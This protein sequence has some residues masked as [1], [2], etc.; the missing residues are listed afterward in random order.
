M[1]E[2]EA[3]AGASLVAAVLEAA[4]GSSGRLEKEGLGGRISRLSDRV[5]EL[6]D[7]VCNMINQRYVEFLPSMQNAQDLE[8]EA[9]ELSSS[10]EQLKS[11]IET[12]VQQDLDVAIAEFT[13]LRQQ[14]ERDS[15]VLS[16][17]KQLQEID[18]ALKQFSA[19]LPE[20]KY[21]S[22]A[23][24]L[25]KA[26]RH[27]KMMES[28][29]GFELKILKALHIELVAQTQNI[30]GVLGEEWKQLAVWKLPQS[31]ETG[32]LESALQTEL[33]L[34]KTVPG[35]DSGVGSSAT[36]VLQGLAILGELNYRFKIFGQLL[37]NYVLKPLISHPSLQSLLEEQSDA[38]VLRLESVGT[39]LGHPSPTEV[40]PKLKLVLEVLHKHLLAVPLDRC[41]GDE[42]DTRP[43]LAEVLGEVIWKELSDCLT[44]DCLVHSIPSSS[45]KLGQYVEVIKAT[46]EFEQALKDMRFL[47]EDSTDLLT[48]ARNVN[49]HFADK[50]CQDVVVTA[51]H[52]MMSE[53]HN[54]V[55]VTPES[56]VGLPELPG[57]AAGDQSCALVAPEVLPIQAGD[58]EAKTRLS[59]HTLS[60]PAC[61]ISESV[62]KLMALAYQTLEEASAGTDH[63]A[64][65]F[66][67]VRH[68]F[69]LFW[70]V[71]PMYHKENLQK[72][73]Q[74]AA[75]HHNNCMYIAHHLLTLGHQFQGCLS[76]L[77]CDGAA[78]FVD[79][80]PIFRRLGTECFLAQMRAQKGEL[81]ERLS[82]AR[83]FS[84]VD[85]EDSYA[86]A[87]K[88]VRQVLHQLKRLGKI[89]QGI[90]PVNVYCKAMGTLLNTA[91]AEII[92][93]I[94][95]LEDISAENADRLFALCQM[96]VEEGPQVF[97]PLPEEK[98]NRPFQEEV[99]LYVPKWM[100]FKELMLV[101]QANLQEIMDRWADSKGPLAAEFS[102]SEVKN[103]IRAL[104]QN[105]ERR[106]AALAKIK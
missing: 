19:L 104:F 58:L 34:R 16:V 95:A 94:L 20:K 12:E 29:R 23:C 65:L 71:V 93:R 27:L 21:V 69:C 30:L 70:D 56:S 73:P 1:A 66:Y 11:M 61:C 97:V 60:F 89:W 13:E 9:E 47:K 4:Q 51:R 26:Q 106:A 40:F 43:V 7:E 50:K 45:S 99:P 42:S 78:T 38:V 55:K 57:R 31:K 102:P 68:I 91:L 28:R 80:V 37:L 49:R 72:L 44:R 36:S 105:T 100:M 54:T 41:A 64:Q 48:Y 32:S 52:L 96:M 3:A 101:L 63:S 15:L 103:L 88:A 10:I 5:E 82:S 59:Q 76:G 83:N 17:L 98:H 14:L 24:H 75:I 6:K 53:I 85:D 92:S 22:A 8:S 81:L 25:S 35:E 62:Q 46:E 39:Q 77:P 79:L 18:S 74:L 67:L 2:T 33:H 90:L 84:T 87:N 86:A